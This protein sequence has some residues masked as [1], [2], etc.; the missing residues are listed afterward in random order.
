[1][2]E[3]MKIEQA[4]ST[5]PEHGS[6]RK[7]EKKGSGGAFFPKFFPAKQGASKARLALR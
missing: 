2:L 3:R 4:T 6:M 7:R 5:G 1:L